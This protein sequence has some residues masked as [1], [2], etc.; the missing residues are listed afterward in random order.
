MLN[1]CYPYGVKIEP[2][3]KIA[4]IN[5]KAIKPIILAIKAIG[6]TEHTL[7]QPVTEH[8]KH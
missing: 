6:N 2:I 1:Y 3:A 5:S 8:K 4:K 7:K